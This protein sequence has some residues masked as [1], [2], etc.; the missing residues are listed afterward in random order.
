MYIYFISQICY[1]I[2]IIMQMKYTLFHKILTI[3]LISV[4][5]TFGTGGNW[6]NGGVDWFNFLGGAGGGGDTVMGWTLMLQSFE[7]RLGEI[8]DGKLNVLV[9]CDKL[10]TIFTNINLT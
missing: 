8:R 6:P 3:W 1:L 9:H 10:R 7:L 4:I 5:G 2:I